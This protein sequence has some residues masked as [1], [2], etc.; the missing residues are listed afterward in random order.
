MANRIKSKHLENVFPS[1]VP[2]FYG[3]ICAILIPW[4]VFLA[5]VLPPRYIS[6]NWDIAWTGFDIF[7]IFLFASTA[8]LAIRKSAYSAISAS[9]LGTVILTDAWFDILTSKPGLAERRSI[10]EAVI[11]EL[12]LAILSFWL[13]QKIFRSTMKN[14]IV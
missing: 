2:Y 9:M 14:D 4:T 5:Y 1:W 12:P 7:M 6:H 10:I 11:I 3:I 13:A 8:I